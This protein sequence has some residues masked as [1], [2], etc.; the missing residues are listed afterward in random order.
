MRKSLFAKYFTA[1]AVIIILS[2]TFLISLAVVLASRFWQS[3]KI[4]LMEQNAES[5]SSTVADV[6]G[7][8][9]F[10][11]ILNR[12][13][14]AVASASNT[15]VFF[16]DKNGNTFVCSDIRNHV[17]CPHIASTVSEEI[18]KEV[19]KGKYIETGLLSGIYTETHY[20]VA[21]PMTDVDGEI[22]GAVFISVSAQGQSEYISRLIQIFLASGAAALSIL[23]VAVYL[24]TKRMVKPL[25]EMSEAAHAMSTGDFSMRIQTGRKDEIGELADAFNKMT[26][27]L[28][29]LEVMR[30]SFVANVSHELKTPMTTI[31]GFVDGILDGTIPD[32]RRNHYLHIVSDEVKRLSS[33]VNT[34]LGLAKLESGQ[35]K[36]KYSKIDLTD[37]VCRTI[38]SLENFIENKHIDIRG[39]D[40]APR[41][42]MMADTN[43]IY[44]AIYN[45]AENAVKF[46]PDGGYIEFSV[47]SDDDNA[48]IS[49]KNSGE[50]LRP[51][52]LQ[53]VF[54]RFYKTDKSRSADKTGMGLGLYIVKSIAAI[55]GGRITVS[56]E[57]GKYTEFTMI[58]PKN[59][60]KKPEI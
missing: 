26:E 24:M 10:S 36:I 53:R 45:L 1:S 44:Q 58:L 2:F 20:T 15:I 51:E 48:V 27:S 54:D 49:I 47:E 43:L 28:E 7:S 34:M 52:E 56:S 8:P 55:H 13:G 23:F 40:E 31:G 21:V 11:L 17:D 46:T 4:D 50:G 12:T 29:S 41:V 39:L 14:S 9:D 22:L 38:I 42:T 57:Y 5:L 25:A 35:T 6:I 37:A 3:E 19:Y 18:M 33:L 30:S 16:V 60:D 59:N 32:D